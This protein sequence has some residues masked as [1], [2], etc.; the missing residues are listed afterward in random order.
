M[1]SENGLGWATLRES[2][3]LK[4]VCFDWN[5]TTKMYR[6]PIASKFSGYLMLRRNMNREHT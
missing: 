1:L 2:C 3:R 4:N 6:I 5:A